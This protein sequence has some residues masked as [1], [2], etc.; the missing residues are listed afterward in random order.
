MADD[1][2]KSES[3][4]TDR[5]LKNKWFWIYLIVAIVVGYGGW[6]YYKKRGAGSSSIE[7]GGSS[8]FVTRLR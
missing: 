1:D 8:I 2:T 7:T 4:L 6:H 3:S 5:T